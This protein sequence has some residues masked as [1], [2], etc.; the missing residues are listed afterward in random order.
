MEI[1]MTQPRSKKSITNSWNQGA[2]IPGSNPEKKDYNL[3]FANL[4]KNKKQLS[5]Y[6]KFARKNLF[7]MTKD[8]FARFITS[9]D[10]LQNIFTKLIDDKYHWNS[11]K[12]SFDKFMCSRILTE[13]ENLVK[14]EKN[15]IPVDINTFL[16]DQESVYNDDT[17]YD[18]QLTR[19]DFIIEPDLTSTDK[20]EDEFDITDLMEAALDFFHDSEIEF[21]VLEEILKNKKPKEIAKSL[22]LT[23]REVR[24]ATLRIRRKLIKWCQKKKH[25]ELLKILLSPVK[26]NNRKGNHRGSGDDK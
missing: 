23:T 17:E 20:K 13:L 1:I 18:K 6:E 11:E 16:S 7:R 12:Y 14:H 21:F 9:E 15:F 3:L 4:L 25:K 10:I 26:K 2:D 24:N 8:R 5:K 22:G 19:E